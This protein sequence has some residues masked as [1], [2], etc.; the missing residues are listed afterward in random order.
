[1]KVDVSK[2]K[3]GHIQITVKRRKKIIFIS[4]L[5]EGDVTLET[6]Y[7]KFDSVES[8]PS[9][10]S[11]WLGLTITHLKNGNNVTDFYH[12]KGPNSTVCGHR[13]V[14]CRPGKRSFRL[15]LAIHYLIN[16]AKKNNTSV[17]KSK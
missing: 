2:N 14:A 9:L 15:N 17:T 7:L 5:E 11:G 16:T 3:R 10:I 8:N 6:D 13:V 4:T 1:M 12:T